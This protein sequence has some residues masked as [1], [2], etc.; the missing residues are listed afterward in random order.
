MCGCSFTIHKTWQGSIE[1]ESVN[2]ELLFRHGLKCASSACRP[3]CYSIFFKYWKHI[4]PLK[5][6]FKLGEQT[7]P[8][9]DISV[10]NRVCI[11][12][13]LLCLVTN[14]HT[15]FDKKAG[16]SCLTRC[17]VLCQGSISAFLNRNLG[18]SF[19]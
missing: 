9:A 13:R 14:C 17:S 15:C 3:L 4:L 19:N 1:A 10:E 11:T 7:K 18:Y 12:Y 2:M 16:T 6:L 8:Q 5:V